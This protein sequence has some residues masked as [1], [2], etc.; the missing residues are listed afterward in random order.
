[1]A[2]PIA[3]IKRPVHFAVA[4]LFGVVAVLPAVVM[5]GQADA[6]Q[7]TTRSIQ[8]ANSASGAN[9]TTYRA[10]FNAATSS[11]V[12]GIIVDICSGA[13]GSGPLLGTTCTSMTGANFSWNAPVAADITTF[14]ING[15]A[16]T[17][18]DT[19][20]SAQWG[21]GTVETGRTL[22]LSSVDGTAVTAG[23]T[24]VVE[25]ANVNNPNDVDGGGS[26]NIG[27]FYGRLATF[28]NDTGANSPATYD[29]ATTGE[30]NLTD[31]GGVALSTT[32]SLTVTARVQESLTFCIYT[33]S[34][35]TGC[36]TA[37]IAAAGVNIPNATTPLSSGS[38]S[39]AS[40]YFGLATNA[41]N[42]ANVRMW[43]NNS[44]NGVL[45][46]GSTRTIN[47]FGG[48][49]DAGTGAPVSGTDDACTVDS[50]ASNTEQ[51]GMLITE[52]TNVVAAMPYDCAAGNHGW[53]NDSVAGA[54][55]NDATTVGSAYGD[56]IASTTGPLD[57]E[58]NIM[59]FAAKS[60]L[61]TEAGIYSSSLNYIAT[62]T[63]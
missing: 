21:V 29:D 20:T 55:A 8:L 46:S 60:A 34:P 41:L 12:K 15:V 30:S 50:T 1:M 9:G 43:S 47:P 52:S 44:S 25:I 62:G 13:A 49:M 33:N 59:E 51:F 3:F 61:T 11:T 5:L 4:L 57:F 32:E 40:A 6:A 19:P 22:Y 58:E 48:T 35:Q 7:L 2:N 24:I 31:F 23:Q 54:G 45:K 53:D 27:T 16:Q 10:S 39:T 26:D 63:Y 28:P 36:T 18:S 14:T 42:G 37:T 56:T 17:V 38:V